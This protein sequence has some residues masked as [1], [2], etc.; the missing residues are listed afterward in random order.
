MGKYNLEELLNSGITNM[1]KQYVLLKLENQDKL[2]FYRL[3]DFYEMFFDDAIIASKELELTLTGRDCGL[4]ERAPMCGIPHHAVSGYLNKL[5]EKG[6]KVAICEQVEDPK[7][8]Q[9]IVRREI[10]R[11]VTPGTVTD[12]A[13]LFDEKNNFLCSLYGD[14][15]ATG[16]VFVDVSTGELNIIK[17]VTDKDYIFKVLSELSKYSP[18]EILINEKTGK[19]KKLIEEIQK[20]FSPLINYISEDRYDFSSAKELIGDRFSKE[21]IDKADLYNSV[22][23][24]YA[25]YMLMD[26]LE[27]TQLNELKHVNSFEY[28]EDCD[29]AYIDISTKRNLELTET[30]REKKKTGS[31][32]GV[33]DKTNT[34]MGARLLRHYIEMPLKSPVHITNRLNA[35]EELYTKT[36]VR[37]K[38][39]EFLDKIYDIERLATKV[40]YRSANGRDLIALKHSLK[41]IPEIKEVLKDVSSFILKDIDKNLDPMEDMVD[42]LERALLEE[43][44]ITITEGDIIKEGYNE[45]LDELQKAKKEGK[46]WIFDIEAQEKEK[47]GIKNLKVGYNKVFGYFIEVTKSYL[48]MVPDYFIRKQTLANCERYITEKLK[49]VENLVIGAEEKSVNLEYQLFTE[50]RDTLFDNLERVQ[51]TAK[52]L[53]KLDVLCSFAFVAYKNHYVKPQITTDGTIVIKEGRHPV[54]EQM[55]KTGA[56]IPNDTYLNLSDNS[57]AII[58]GPNMA[59][60]STYM[61][62]VALMSVMAQIGSFV[63]AR[64]ATLPVVDK[65]FTRVG[66]SDDLASGQSTFMVEMSEVAN[67]LKNATKDSLIILDEIGRGTSTFDGLSIAWSVV[68]YILKKISAKTLFATHYHELTI[69]EDKLKGVKNYQIAVKK[70]GDDITFLR[71][72]I[73]GGTDDSFGIEVSKLAGV[74]DEVVRRAKEIVK[75]LESKEIAVNDINLKAIPAPVKEDKEQIGFSSIV[76]DSVMKTLKTIDVTTLTPVEALNILNDLSRKVKEI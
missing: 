46:A 20:K 32:L 31:L 64:S 61:R 71:K 63:P 22:Q 58:T 17:P 69:L 12:D 6:Y 1:M 9:G 14:E 13:S 38:L 2:I 62:Q 36:D 49:E 57:F 25:L 10:V 7:T 42:L 55:V 59:G 44:P 41:M 26:Y 33:L 5:I 27:N 76:D 8:A 24:V 29:F 72:I 39:C 73:E 37:E 52:A 75:I 35:V 16:L 18:K 3:G 66:A 11:V 4:P 34:S 23:S 68:E 51:K 48:S 65:I 43:Q 28:Y 40:S 45:K 56:F 47:T 53:A 67:I 19:N 50:I 21:E 30:L 74:P 60:K 70:R 54:V 15:V